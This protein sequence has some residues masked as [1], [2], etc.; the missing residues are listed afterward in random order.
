MVITLQ[1]ETLITAITSTMDESKKVERELVAIQERQVGEDDT[2]SGCLK[3]PHFSVL[4]PFG[5]KTLS[6]KLPHLPKKDLKTQSVLVSHK[7]ILKGKPQAAGDI[8]IHSL[9]TDLQTAET[10]GAELQVASYSEL[11]LLSSPSSSS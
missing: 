4:V 1:V 11:S 6:G 8:Y 9:L 2:N 7:T 10:E 3:I 5:L